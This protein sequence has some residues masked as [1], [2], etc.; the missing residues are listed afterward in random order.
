MIKMIL[1]S[2]LRVEHNWLCVV[3]SVGREVYSG[4]D[5]R[6]RV[7]HL[8]LHNS[9]VDVK[10]EILLFHGLRPLRAERIACRDRLP[11]YLVG[12][13]LV[14]AAKKQMHTLHHSIWLDRLRPRLHSRTP[15]HLARSHR[16]CHSGGF[17]LSAELESDS[18]SLLAIPVA[19]VGTSALF[20]A[21]GFSINLTSMFGLVLAIGTVVEAAQRNI[22]DGM[23][24]REATGPDV[25]QAEQLLH[26]APAFCSPA[27]RLLSS[28]NQ[29]DRN[30]FSLWFSHAQKPAE[31][32]KEE[33]HA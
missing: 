10:N 6:W 2:F 32:E 33:F 8:D 26:T 14:Q 17:H 18:H 3:L 15:A 5:R 1:M 31:N 27:V 9:V 19:I 11:R 13:E 12:W 25:H 16:A 21:L 22:D 23:A 24:P 30:N 7:V 4:L 29:C 20:P 28:Q